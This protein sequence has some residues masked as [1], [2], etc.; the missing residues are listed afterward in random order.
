MGIAREQKITLTNSSYVNFFVDIEILSFIEI[1]L[2]VSNVTFFGASDFCW[3]L[4][5]FFN[6]L[7]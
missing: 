1:V 3:Y 5:S 7:V 6:L 2:E 4:L